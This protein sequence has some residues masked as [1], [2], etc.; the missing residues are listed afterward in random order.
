MVIFLR[1]GQCSTSA[2][3]QNTN[4]PDDVALL[5]GA[6]CNSGRFERYIV[7]L[8]IISWHTCKHQILDRI[9]Q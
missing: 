8:R 4:R 1:Q 5:P 2:E 7:N 9:G 3:L 6:K